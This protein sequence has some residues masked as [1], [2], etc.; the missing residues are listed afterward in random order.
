MPQIDDLPAADGE[1]DEDGQDTEPLDAISSHLAAGAQLHLLPARVVVFAG[2][3]SNESFHIFQ[4]LLRV[5]MQKNNWLTV[6]ASD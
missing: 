6:S 1:K 5:Q 3:V 2:N 4:I